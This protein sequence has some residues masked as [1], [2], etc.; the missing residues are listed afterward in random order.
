MDTN[1]IASGQE[2][3]VFRAAWQNRLPLLLKGPTG[4]GK[5][6]FVQSMARLLGRELITVACHEDLTAGDLI[7]RFLLDG[8]KTI[9]QDGPL[10]KAVREG[11]ICYLDEIVEARADTT[12]VIHP[13]ADHRRELN[14]ERLGEMIAAPPEFMLVMSYNPGYQ[15]VLKDLKPSTRQRMVALELTYPDAPVEERILMQEASA[16]P[17][18]ASRLVR[19]G[20]AIRALPQDGLSDGASTRSLISAA[21]LMAA[22]LASELAVKSAIIAPLSDD[23]VTSR[24]LGEMAKIYL[25]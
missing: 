12:V 25:A 18:L 19:L 4:C 22:G 9:W 6:K 15:S 5:T 21:R 24:N 10:T 2:E 1:Y 13:L 16:P 14:I 7:G 23:P 11:A 8:V 3:E 17:E 20:R